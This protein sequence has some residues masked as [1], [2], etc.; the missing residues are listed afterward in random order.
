[1][2]EFIHLAS[3]MASD[4]TQWINTVDPL[5]ALLIG[6]GI[7]NVICLILFVM[8][9]FYSC[10]G[11]ASSPSPSPVTSCS[12]SLDQY[13]ETQQRNC[14]IPGSDTILTGVALVAKKQRM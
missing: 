12:A 1:M 14:S 8:T 3:Y 4:F 13:F 10:Y 7:G 11:T 9:A 6:M 5:N 2:A